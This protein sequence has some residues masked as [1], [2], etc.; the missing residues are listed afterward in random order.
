MI[1]QDT[2]LN[3]LERHLGKHYGK[4]AGVVVDNK[5]KATD[6]GAAYGKI[7]V[8]VPAIFPEDMAVW[9]RPCF[10]FGHFFVP[11][12]GTNVWIE[13]EG[14][15][16]RYPIWTGAWYAKDKKPKK[17][18]TSDDDPTNRMIRTPSGHEVEL[19]DTGGKEKIKVN[20]KIG[21]GEGG[22]RYIEIDN[23]H[24]MIKYDDGGTI[25]VSKKDGKIEVIL[26]SG[27]GGSK[28]F[29]LMDKKGIHIDTPD[30][31]IKLTVTAGK[32]NIVAKDIQ[33]TSL[34]NIK[35]QALA[36]FSLASPKIDL[37][38]AAISLKAGQIALGAPSI[39]M[40]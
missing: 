11:N 37:N 39:S 30:E 23:D 38:G 1:I 3:D 8:K 26:Q 36:S 2:R 33:V 17:S 40:G 15:D 25:E 6:E 21:D 35:M 7:K 4:Y 9:A 29:I 32:L 22:D 5:D 13:F 34:T 16:L 20:H 14:G 31:E 12:V 18:N 19:D 28:K 24:T 27:Q 10:P